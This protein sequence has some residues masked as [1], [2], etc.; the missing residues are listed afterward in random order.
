MAEVTDGFLH[1]TRLLCNPLA[2]ATLHL[3]A[4]SPLLLHLLIVYYYF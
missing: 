1:L 3:Q 4:A 2:T